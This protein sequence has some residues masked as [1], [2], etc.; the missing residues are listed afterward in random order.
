MVDDW[1]GITTKGRKRSLLMSKKRINRR[2]H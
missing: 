2:Y 1:K